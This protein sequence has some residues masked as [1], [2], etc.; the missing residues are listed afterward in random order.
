MRG[1]FDPIV[2][3]SPFGGTLRGELVAGGTSGKINPE[4]D[5]DVK[6]GTDRSMFVYVPKS[7]C[8][9][10]KQTQVLMVLRADAGEQSAR[11]ALDGLGLARLAEDRHFLVVFPNPEEGGWNFELD[12]ARED[13]ASFI[14][15]C[16]AALPRLEAHVAGFNGM[17]FHLACDETS[18]AMALALAASSPLDAAAVM[19]GSTPEG[20]EFSGMASQ[21]AWLYERNEQAAA[22]LDEVDDVISECEPATGVVRH[23]GTEGPSICWYQSMG[24]LDAET[25]VQA[26][27]LMFSETRRWRNDSFGTY[28]PRVHF[29]ELGFVSHVGEVLPGTGDELP[30]SWHEFVPEGVRTSAE[31][32]P[33]V[34]YLHGIN[35]V[36]LYGAEQSG[37]A[38]I[39]QREGL[40]AVF[41]DATIENRWNVWDDPCLPSDVAFIRALIEH[42]DRVHPVDRRRVYVSG[43]SM[44]SMFSNTLAA[45]CPEL[46]AGAV[47]LNGPALG[48]LETLDQSRPGMA[49]LNPSSVITQLERSDEPL[50]PAR[51][52]ADR[53]AGDSCTKMP[54]VQ[55]VG[56]LDSVGIGVGHS[57]PVQ[58]ADDGMWPQ[59]VAFW[60]RFDG[61]AAAP[62]MDASTPTGIASDSCVREGERYWHQSW[63]VG[64]DVGL[65]HLISA[66]RMPHAVAL[67]EVELGWEIVRRWVRNADGSLEWLG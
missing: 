34:I 51:V 42:M 52:E 30:R 58:D 23:V 63:S 32:A 20:F 19:V 66:E 24:G 60:K 62:L 45:S 22:R 43:F 54:F 56:L 28:Q 44:G 6:A 35:C 38:S 15:R 59:T 47:A 8:P 7:G 26:W 1:V 4:N 2:Q 64:S 14:V 13:D 57:W 39:A 29:A 40:M 65:Y 16:F 17:I 55:F 33:L 27:D 10:A 25:L 67:D 53:H 3:F 49:L 5:V 11:R 21:V 50:S 36:G 12:P 37:W 31:P 48:L 61:I 46:F 9:H 18:S 41:P